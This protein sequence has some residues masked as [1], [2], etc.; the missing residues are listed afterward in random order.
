MIKE[1]VIELKEHDQPVVVTWSES[2]DDYV[3]SLAEPLPLHK[4]QRVLDKIERATQ[5]EG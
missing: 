2:E 1:L 4:M 3:I 5:Y